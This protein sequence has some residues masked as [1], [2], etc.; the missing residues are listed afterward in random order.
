MGAQT[1]KE[2]PRRLA[3]IDNSQEQRIETGIGEFDRVL[4]GGI[5]KGSIILVGGDPGIGKSTLMMQMARSLMTVRILYVSGEES[6]KQIK[7]RAQRLGMSNEDFSVLSETNVEAVLDAAREHQPDILIIDSIQTM[8][9]SMI[10]SAPGSVGQVRESTALL[11]QYAKTSGVPVFVIGHVTKEGSIAGPKVLE[12]IVDTVLQF[13]GERT[14]AYRILRAAKN[15]YGSTNE[16]GVFQMT[17]EGL[18]EVPNPSEI[19]L[20]ERQDGS[21]GSVVSAIL[22]GTRPVLLEVQALVSASYFNNPQRTITG[23]DQRRTSMLLAV[24]EKRLGIRI[25]QSDVFIN[26]AGGLYIDE[27]AVDLAIAMAVVSSHRDVPAN[28]GTCLIGEIGL[29]GEVRAVPQ[30]EMRVQEALKLG[31]EHIIVPKANLKALDR[32]TKGKKISGIDRV[33]QA[34]DLLF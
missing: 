6:A 13:E 18:M 12:H 11:M 20:S 29:G 23:Y 21:S 10:E 31:F 19:F 32:M 9:R 28:P 4:G 7:M 2:H 16:I 5:T 17:S 22:E 26:I 14:H 3:E 24:L 27:P 34:V 25:S 30:P 33:G 1:G 15:R 8:F